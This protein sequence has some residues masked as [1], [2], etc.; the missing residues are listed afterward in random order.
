MRHV[1][2][3]QVL[4]LR[5]AQ[6]KDM[7]LLQQKASEFFYSHLL[8]ALEKIFDKLSDENNTIEIDR[9][10]LDLGLI[11]WDKDLQE[12]KIEELLSKLEKQVEKITGKATAPDYLATKESRDSKIKKKTFSQNACEQWLHYMQTGVLPWN[13]TGIDDEWRNRVLETLATDYELVTRMKEMVTQ[14]KRILQRIVRDHAISF[15]V[16]L[17]EIITAQQQQSLLQL[18]QEIEWILTPGLPLTVT[19]ESNPPKK[20]A[21]GIWQYLLKN[22]ATT[23][24]SFSAAQ[25]AK[26]WLEQGIENKEV[27]PERLK[28]IKHE[29]SLLVTVIQEVLD[30]R[31]KPAGNKASE[32]GQE[33]GEKQKNAEIAP[34]EKS[35]PA[36]EI[37]STNDPQ[38]DLLAHQSNEGKNNVKEEDGA[39]QESAAPAMVADNKAMGEEGIYVQHL[40]VILLH[41]FFKSFFQRTN[42]VAEGRFNSRAA[43]EKAIHL[44]HYLVT[45]SREAE[46]HLLAVPKIICG[47]PLEE[48]LS[49]ETGLTAVET[50][51]AGDLLNAAIAQWT[52]LKNTS[53]DGLREGFLQRNG[54]VQVKNSNMHFLV[55]SSA[56]D[57]LLDHLPWNL[58]MVKLPWL[59]DL[60][61]VEWR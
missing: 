26:Q 15:L 55:E 19:V 30:T 42:L 59:S 5:F 40:G 22:A 45:G 23:S 61:R 17:I 8:P 35:T 56:I 13:L 31:E 29:I 46:E 53:A 27:Q 28:H 41:P 43:Q 48:P 37:R 7:F 6:G 34:Q 2:K 50:V 11:E 60:I 25:L 51:E 12:I 38:K 14:D 54:K 21:A 36:K 4:E 3:K 24:G 33:A 47:W 16:K 44:L 10:E 20:E 57:V 39:R 58:S 52:I 9:L 18:V 1:I 49:W 32:S